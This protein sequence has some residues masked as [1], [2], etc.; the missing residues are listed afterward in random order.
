MAC[1]L[2]GTFSEESAWFHG[3]RVRHRRA[4]YRPSSKGPS[5]VHIKTTKKPMRFSF[6]DKTRTMPAC[7]GYGRGTGASVAPVRGLSPRARGMMCLVSTQFRLEWD[8]GDLRLCANKNA[9]PRCG[10]SKPRLVLAPY[11]GEVSERLKE[12]AWKVCVRQKRTEGS[13][14]SLSA[15]PPR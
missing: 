7:R 5:A 6:H 14:P 3:V 1:E 12:H 2:D 8:G 4:V 13:N 11:R 15:N 10:E 9:A